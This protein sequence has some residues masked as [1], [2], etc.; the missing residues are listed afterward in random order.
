MHYPVLREHNQE[1]DY[2]ANLWTERDRKV[3][4]EK[5]KNIEAWR[6]AAK[7]RTVEVGVEL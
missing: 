7:R 2:L 6:A 1:A 3:T 5:D 4:V